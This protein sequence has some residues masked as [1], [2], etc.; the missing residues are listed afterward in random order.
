MVIVLSTSDNFHANLVQGSLEKRGIDVVRV[1]FDKIPISRC[2]FSNRKGDSIVVCG[3]DIY[4]ADVSGVFTHHPRILIN[5]LSGSDSLDATLH[6]SSWLNFLNWME[7]F[8]PSVRWVNSLHRIFS[9]S[10]V[11][12]QLDLAERNGFITPK[13]CFSNDVSEVRKFF[14]DVDSVILKTGPLQGIFMPGRRILANVVSLSSIDPEILS[15]SP[16]LFQEYVEK[17]FELRIHV[18]DDEVFVCKIDSQASNSKKTRVDWR[19]YSLSDTP[20]FPF[21]LD[22]LTANKV[23]GL[24][25]LFGLRMCIFDFIVTKDQKLVFL[26]CNSQGYWSWIEDLTGLKIT[27][28]V[29]NS[30]IKTK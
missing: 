28:A 27:N 8:I 14:G 26:E 29:V 18:V 17:S 5:S 13:T 19:N 2:L 9:T 23:R 15:T 12:D 22:S 24:A 10:S 30:L 21:S 25:S 4:P 1:D 6:R 3:R 7:D 16:C 11:F 20:H